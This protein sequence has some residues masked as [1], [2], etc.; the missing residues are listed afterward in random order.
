MVYDGQTT[1]MINKNKR[2]LAKA[3]GLN[4]SD[5]LD[6]ALNVILDI[7]N[8]NELDLNNYLVQID[9]TNKGLDEL[10]KT[11]QVK[12][13]LLNN[14]INDLNEKEKDILKEKEQ[15]IK[16]YEKTL[17]DLKQQKDN[18]KLEKQQTIK[19]YDLKI[20]E[21]KLQKDE[22]EKGKKEQDEIENILKEIG[23]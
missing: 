5:V 10:E 1:I 22:L 19:D 3:K 16:S 12:I 4:L 20:N 18:L 7:N 17:K 9:R 11:K 6:N 15:A 2:D 8:L 14:K 21:L 13:D 23:E